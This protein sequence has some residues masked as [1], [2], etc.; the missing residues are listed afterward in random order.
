[1]GVGNKLTSPSRIRKFACIPKSYDNSSKIDK[2]S[3]RLERIEKTLEK[4]DDHL[5][6]LGNVP[7]RP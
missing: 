2:E 5:E 7:K 3:E 4:L 6:R 1:M